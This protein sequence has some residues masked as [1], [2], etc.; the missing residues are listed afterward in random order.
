MIR[1]DINRREYKL[2]AY[3]TIVSMGLQLF[4]PLNVS[5]AQSNGAGQGSVVGGEPS[6]MVDLFSGDFNYS[7]PIMNVDGFP[8]TL[9]YNGNVHMQ[10]DASWVGLGWS[11]NPGAI[12]RE[13]RG[14]PDD[15]DGDPVTKVDS[16]KSDVTVGVNAG[17]GS[18]AR[19]TPFYI[20][21]ELKGGRFHNS[22]SGWGTN[23]DY[24]VSAGVGSSIPE[25]DFDI[26]GNLGV[27]GGI[28]LN[29]RNGIGWYSSGNVSL[30]V[31]FDI[32]GVPAL[33]L[34][35]S[36][37]I[38]TSNSSRGTK[39]KTL[40]FGSSYSTGIMN[41][42]SYG[43]RQITMGTKT[44]TPYIS[45]SSVGSSSNFRSSL[46][47]KFI[48]GPS[49][50]TPYGLYEEYDS[51]QHS[52][53]EIDVLPAYGYMNLE[54]GDER[55]GALLDFN[56]ENQS[57]ISHETKVLPVTSLTHDIFRVSGSSGGFTFRA[58]RNDVG[59]VSNNLNTANS[60]GTSTT[61]AAEI[62]LPATGITGGEIRVGT[63]GSITRGITKKW[64]SEASN[65]LSYTDVK[66][67][68]ID[69]ETYYF[70][71]TGE[72]TPY[73]KQFYDQYGGDEAV[74]VKIR[75]SGS[76]YLADAI[77]ETQS[78]D[79][80]LPAENYQEHKQ[81]R[82]TLYSTLSASE[83]T[84]YGF[85]SQIPHYSESNSS[86]TVAEQSYARNS[87]VRKDHHISEIS[88]TKSGGS[89]CI[90]NIPTYSFYN[91]SR[92][93]N[94]SEDPLTSSS[95]SVNPDVQNLVDY[96]NSAN[97]TAN[98]QGRDH[99][100]HNTRMEGYATSFLLRAIL[101]D[102]YNDRTGDGMT[103]DDLGSYM[104]LNYT[105]VY[106]DL[107]PFKWRTPNDLNKANYMENIKSYDDDNI[108]HIE[109]GEKE[110]WYV[111][112]IEGKNYIAEF[113][114]SDR[115]DMFSVNGING[116]LDQ[117]KPGKKLEKIVLFNKHDRE[118]NG[119]NAEAIQT[120]EFEYDYSLCPGY[121]GNPNGGGKLT[122]KSITTT[123]SD[124]KK[125]K[126]SPYQFV[127]GGENY[128]YNP[129]E[130]D[131]W[132]A[133]KAD[134]SVS[135]VKNEDYPY[136]NQNKTQRDKDVAPWSLTDII[137]PTNG[138]M[139]IE[140]ESDDYGYTENKDAMEMFPIFALGEEAEIANYPSNTNDEF[141]VG[142]T[143][144]KRKKPHD[145]IYLNIPFSP[146]GPATAKQELY[147]QF[148]KPI[149]EEH[150]GKVFYKC[151][152]EMSNNEG[153]Y[154]Y[155]SGFMD[156][157]DYGVT[158]VTSGM[159]PYIKV[160]TQIVDE[161]N[162]TYQVN[163]IMKN[164][165]QFL[166]RNA[167][168]IIFPD[169]GIS[170][171]DWNTVISGLNKALNRL[172]YCKRMDT[173]ESFIRLCSPD[174]NK[175][176]GGHRVASITYTDNWNAMVNNESSFTYGQTFT[177]ENE[178]GTSSG[179]A[180]FEPTIGNEINPFTQPE[181]YTI[182]NQNYPDDH[183]YHEAPFGE[184]FFAA[185]GIG[186]SRVVVEN[187]EH[188]GVT[189]NT[190][191]NTVHEFYTAFEHP[192]ITSRTEVNNGGPIAVVLGDTQYDKIAFSQGFSIIKNDMHGKP[193]FVTNYSEGG[194]EISRQEY[195]YKDVDDVCSLIN[196]KNETVQD[197]I[198]G[199]D[200]D[201]VCD[202]METS[203]LRYSYN[204][205]IVAGAWTLDPQE[206][207]FPYIREV[208]SVSTIE[209]GYNLITL[210]KV[211]QNYAVLDH[212]KT[213]HL[214]AKATQ[215][216]LAFD[217]QT[218][219]VLVMNTDNEWENDNSLESRVYSASVPAY[220][221]Y[222][223]M[224]HA[225]N[226]FGNHV[227]GVDFTNG[228]AD[229][230]GSITDSE[231]YFEVGDVLKVNNGDR[232]LL[233]VLE[234]DEATDQLLCIKQDG[235]LADDINNANI[236]VIRSGHKN[237]QSAS[238]STLSSLE[239]PIV[240]N[241]INPPTVLAAQAME[242]DQNRTM[243]ASRPAGCASTVN[244]CNPAIG[245][246][247][248]PF[249][250]GIMN[251]WRPNKSYAYQVDRAQTNTATAVNL[252]SDGDYGAFVS[253]FKNTGTQYD[254]ITHADH[255]DYNSGDTEKWLLTNE[256]TAYNENG[257]V[258]ETRDVLNRYSGA[259]YG[260]NNNTETVPM[261]QGNN[262]RHQ[263][264]AFDG[265]ED[266]DYLTGSCAEEGHF[267]FE[268]TGRIVEDEAHTG[269]R[270]LKLLSG[271]EVSTSRYTKPSS[272]SCVDP[273]S[274]QGFELQRCNVEELFSPTPGDYIVG[275]WVKEEGQ[276]EAL[277]YGNP[278]IE[279]IVTSA[280]GSVV[281]QKSFQVV[282]SDK[283]DG[284]QR[285]EGEFE[286]PSTAYCI[287]V[288]LKHRGGSSGD[289]YFDDLRIHPFNST[290]MT[291]V[292]DPLSLRKWADLDDYNFATF[293]EYNEQGL[294]VRVKRET[295]E[296]IKTIQES[297][298]ALVKQP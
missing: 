91:E 148:L 2:L 267:D 65:N 99:F 188:P 230:S 168:R 74:N 220:W 142:N 69:N 281:E 149:M 291:S 170:N 221:H 141:R 60:D 240:N 209:E 45:S 79:L 296:G 150:G 112:S 119:A 204:N 290:M 30:G 275:A 269:R 166:R 61:V 164:S 128:A 124:S 57:Q 277:K 169:N 72:M 234:I 4:Y 34:G 213:S 216:N 171:V 151:K 162:G 19:I 246:Y 126:L 67:K 25:I 64:D 140:Y 260:Y 251:N 231:K 288:K 236:E 31:G 10:Q 173:S 86:G 292:F 279:V 239:N 103:E 133:Y 271:E 62:G 175:L 52:L 116:G 255:P 159:V 40:G 224:A 298:T 194:A 137:L 107:N 104:K 118:L 242:F 203:M 179:V 153:N 49:I 100:Y 80:T 122:L 268:V 94:V 38:S 223:G 199:K 54:K 71:T 152:V 214:G 237:Q 43:T 185:P 259:L 7:I 227:S 129:Y 85:E 266:Y 106:D 77:L 84:V 98:Q 37:S 63:G 211:I 105:R 217:D 190:T 247:I 125:G 228:Y 73:N 270:A 15:F 8:L 232:G 51:E 42:G 121:N 92:S 256:V 81:V 53:S 206:M 210:T 14:L 201:I 252:M 17:V 205:L 111:Q 262:A 36:T 177:Y 55:T 248:N 218:G 165:W 109:Y 59:T 225:S 257:N 68:D 163:P 174:H 101:S 12:N 127:Y 200:I 198:I 82:N 41:K 130:V 241:V 280:G 207:P 27:S 189:Q 76:S 114:L 131:R 176:G 16:R 50:L 272:F 102:D 156:I 180:S 58:Y 191:G 289:V 88:V 158:D 243:S 123:Y 195:H 66:S 120:V 219:Q 145:I 6:Q 187:I 139:H 197:Q 97:S 154:E 135:G 70:K 278:S 22:Y 56:R 161:E 157:E 93:F 95:P 264:L 146:S 155:V 117:S 263:D 47:Y 172:K 249:L 20:G 284:W 28:N 294:L 235:T 5:M 21:S 283:I 32:I 26:N 83:A 226:T 287:E 178:D 276:E 186:Y 244:S 295:E 35:G 192:T 182:V 285:I 96:Q 44:Y 11:L 136:A 238:V 23:F 78:V 282:E 39:T 253:F 132:G 261:A 13:M 160:K 33:G 144:S 167:S 1:F 183:L 113:Y 212:V 24:Q 75:K 265:F 87:G 108:G 147:D 18:T 196:S 286:I 143:V 3:I 115:E 134:G 89:K 233:W 138:G 250:K 184:S 9:T 90:Y 229:I 258:V 274:P 293:Y 181:E 48:A 202:V 245:D 254:P 110:L 273:I 215:R 222:S 193:K 297:R 46:G 29:T 208:N